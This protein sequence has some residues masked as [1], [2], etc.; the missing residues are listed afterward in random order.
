MVLNLMMK[1]LIVMFK[2]ICIAIFYLDG[3]KQL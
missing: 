1:I 2:N 3:D